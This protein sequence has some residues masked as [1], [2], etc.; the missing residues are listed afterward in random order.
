MRSTPT[1]QKHYFISKSVEQPKYPSRW[2]I[3]L[4]FLRWCKI[5]RTL[6]W[7]T[8][9]K[10]IHCPFVGVLMSIFTA[11]KLSQFKIEAKNFVHF[12]SCTQSQMSKTG[13]K[14]FKS[15]GKHFW[16]W[17]RIPAVSY[18]FFW[19]T[20]TKFQLLAPTR[21][22]AETFRPSSVQTLSIATQ[23]L[24]GRSRWSPRWSWITSWW[25]CSFKML[26]IFSN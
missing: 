13:P 7:A 3:W 16:H 24:G 25:S 6:C 15:A 9:G 18:N 22:A 2:F 8:Q 11:T 17:T 19:L 26:K 20:S 1:S 12:F 23:K 14:L 4:G 10:H 5:S 21:W